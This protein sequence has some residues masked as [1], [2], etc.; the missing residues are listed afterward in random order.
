VVY[1]GADFEAVHFDDVALV[2]GVVG[3]VDEVVLV[4][5]KVLSGSGC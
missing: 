5:G 3:V 4:V 1:G 2:E